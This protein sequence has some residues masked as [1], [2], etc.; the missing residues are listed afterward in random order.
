M[1]DS[2]DRIKSAPV[3]AKAYEPEIPG[4]PRIVGNFDSD[5]SQLIRERQK[6]RSNMMGI[7]LLS[8]CVL[9]FAITIA[10]IGI[11]G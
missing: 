2:P 8:L 9:F 5:Q 3:G 1:N 4:A 11:W 6:S 10:K 7:I